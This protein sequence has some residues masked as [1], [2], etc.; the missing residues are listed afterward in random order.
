MDPVWWDEGQEVVQAEVARVHYNDSWGSHG[1]L[2]KQ[3]DGEVKFWPDEHKTLVQQPLTEQHLPEPAR[4]L[5]E[6]IDF[7]A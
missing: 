1:L 4:A 6:A 5:A 3:R 7:T 2:V